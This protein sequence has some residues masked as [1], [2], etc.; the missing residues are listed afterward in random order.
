MWMN[1]F[2]VQ[3]SLAAKFQDL[4]LHG[5]LWAL[6]DWYVTY[7]HGVMASFDKKLYLEI[8]LVVL[9]RLTMSFD[10]SF[11]QIMFTGCVYG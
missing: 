3:M 10:G 5:Y 9:V 8:E 6:T 7:F 4:F 1:K 11:R 2:L